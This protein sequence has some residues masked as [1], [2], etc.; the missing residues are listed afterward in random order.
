MKTESESITEFDIFKKLLLDMSQEQSQE[1]LLEMTV[2]RLA[3]LD[4]VALARIWIK[5]A[6][7]ICSACTKNR[8]K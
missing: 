7:D 1:T 3:S 2:K 4:H 8:C 6:G 5:K